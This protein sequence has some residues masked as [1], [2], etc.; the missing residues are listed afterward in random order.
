MLVAQTCSSQ[1]MHFYLDNDSLIVK[2]FSIV[3][4]TLVIVAWASVELLIGI[5]GVISINNKEI[6]E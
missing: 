2:L 1:P 3:V 5:G 4:P 6:I